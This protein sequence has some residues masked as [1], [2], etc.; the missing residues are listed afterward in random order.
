MTTTEKAPIQA[1]SATPARAR[2]TPTRSG[3]ATW[4]DNVASAFE[5]LWSNRMRSLLT[6][7]GVI[8]GVS[9]VIAVVTLTQGTSAQINS[10]FASL[11]TNVLTIIPGATSSG[12]A[13]GGLGTQQSL[14]NADANAVSTVAHVASVSP[15]ISASLQ[16]VAGSTNWNTRVQGVAAAMYAIQNL[17]MAQ[18][19][20]FTDQDGASGLPVAV[21]GDT[22][23]QN[24]FGASGANPV[25][26]SVLIRGQAFR[27]VGTL[28]AKGASGFANQDDVI[29]VPFQVAQSR[30]NNSQFVGQI[31]AQ[32]DSA[33]NVNQAQLDIAS[34]LRDRHQLPSDG[35]RDDFTVR[36]STQFVQTAQQF[37]TTLTLLL[38][39]I[40]AIS[41]LVGGIGIMNIML[42]SVTER[43]REI[44][45]RMAVG[46]SRGN[47][48]NQFLIEA[49][50]LSSIGGLLGVVI[51]LIGGFGLTTSNS[52]PFVISV[53]AIVL[54]LVVAGAIG[55]CFGLYPAIRAS[56]LDPIVALRT[57]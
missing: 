1:Q 15:V 47:I 57:E 10:R 34:L 51:G 53:P 43:T 3:S 6:V 5:A 24:L 28:T 31:Q 18:G 4:A 39:G 22:V 38:V 25:G 20:W 19:S 16:V 2:V 12:G 7:L 36:S 35:S 8:I 49:L 50:A 27:V 23:V 41:L 45:I 37:E 55:L 26:Q 46:A 40:A 32:I 29:Y 17:Q 44:G 11:G 54:A 33:D 56:R 52:L 42:V 14:T 9:A 48:R 13:S 30:L 21:L